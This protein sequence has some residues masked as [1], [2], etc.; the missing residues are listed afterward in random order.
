MT[1]IDPKLGKSYS[2]K[3]LLQ[4]KQLNKILDKKHSVNSFFGKRTITNST[5]QNGS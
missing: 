1:S 2:S 5:T 3:V 4:V